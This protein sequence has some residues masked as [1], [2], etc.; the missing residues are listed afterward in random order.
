MTKIMI[1]IYIFSLVCSLG[2]LFFLLYKKKHA[3]SRPS[4]KELA[5]E[6]RKDVKNYLYVLS[7]IYGQIPVIR[8]YY[9]KIKAK[10]KALYPAD[11]ITLNKK[12][13]ERMSFCLVVCI[14]IFA[15]TAIICRFDFWY[16]VAG[17][18]TCYIIL[19]TM[20]NLSEEKMQRELL[21]QLDNL[22]TDIHVYYHDTKM[23]EEAISL[24]ID[25]Q[26]Y[27][28]SLHAEQIYEIVTSADI[29]A[30]VSGYVDVAP[31]RHLLLLAAICASVKKYGDKVLEGGKS[32]FTMNL[33]YLKS[34]LDME[35]I[36]LER[37]VLAF[38]GMGFSVLL[39]TF[40]LKPIESFMVPR[41]E[42]TKVF[43]GG[44]GGVICLAVVLATT[45]ICY[46]AINILKDERD[47]SFGNDRLCLK[48]AEIPIIQKYLNRYMDRN[49]SK[50]MR[51]T[52]DL[53]ATGYKYGSNVFLVKR[54]LVALLLFVSVNVVALVGIHRTREM[55]LTDYTDS[56][57][58]ASV[59]SAT[60]R[61]QMIQVSP[62][63]SKY[64]QRLNISK[65]ELQNIVFSDIGDARLA[66]IITKELLA[67]NG[68]LQNQYYHW[69][70]LILSLG[71][72]VIGYFIP[73]LLIQY[74][75]KIMGLNREDEV[76]QFRTLILILM[77]EDGIMIDTILEW[78][79]RFAHAFKSSLSDCII[80][81]EY[82]QQKALE[83]M[84]DSEFGFAPFR[85]LCESLLSAD[86]V[87]IAKA[88]DYLET[89]RAYYQK[90]REIDNED[91]LNKCHQ[92]AR[93]LMLIPVYEI[94][95]LYII[96]PFCF[97]AYNIY[98]N[99]QNII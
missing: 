84:R 81:L 75:K 38:S 62:T 26:P 88:F 53:K 31:N 83:Q 30:A 11:E 4:D 61:Q 16:S 87:G 55:I 24:A 13:T 76:A 10:Y 40:F 41:F 43:Y 35:R 66:A 59:S 12:A 95:V 49:Y 14:G 18:L 27:E 78:M 85:R 34:D 2:L 99:F 48:I 72:G 9:G 74:K 32:L 77:H 21:N 19:T 3:T 91:I 58:T 86:K 37:R 90:K 45:F 68:R 5:W 92:K 96:T 7:I 33:D 57:T 8:R 69:Y 6:K 64:V 46:E 23:V 63:Y 50:A 80:N 42:G 54:L 71:M 44:L 79:E 73:Y 93:F 39:P 15:L 25:I 20:V 51:S 97:Y 82:S 29:D 22:V 89:E 47:G 1:F 28:I 67:R 94:I 98:Q 60:E 70:I 17:L 65:E 52:D 56:Y 36:R